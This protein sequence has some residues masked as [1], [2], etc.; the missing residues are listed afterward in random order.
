MYIV[1]TLFCRHL[2]LLF[3][4]ADQN[5]RKNKLSEVVS[6]RI[7]KTGISIVLFIPI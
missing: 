7:Y 6:V 1:F 2:M 3:K 4:I 5:E